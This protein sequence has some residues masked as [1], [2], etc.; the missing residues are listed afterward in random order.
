MLVLWV[1]TVLWVFVSCCLHCTII[2]TSFGCVWYMCVYVY[3]CV[4]LGRVV[5]ISIPFGFTHHR[6]H[7]H[8]LT[9]NTHT[10]TPHAHT[11]RL[12]QSVEFTVYT[13]LHAR[14]STIQYSTHTHTHTHTYTHTHVY[15]YVSIILFECCFHFYSFWFH[16]PLHSLI[17]THTRTHT[18]THTPS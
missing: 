9:H 12:P 14:H 18:H 16:A 2:W 6:N 13:H 11:T 4:V 7:H 15:R 3:V 1:C 10:H 8:I 5:F 17:H